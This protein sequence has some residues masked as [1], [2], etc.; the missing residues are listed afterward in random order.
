VRHQ[1]RRQKFRNVGD[2]AHPLG[3]MNQR[4]QRMSFTATVL[5][6]ESKNR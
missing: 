5:G 1:I 2:A 6:I 3:R 4:N